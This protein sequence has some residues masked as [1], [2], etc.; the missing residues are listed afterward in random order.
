[1]IGKVL[2]FKPLADRV[3]DDVEYV[4][5]NGV[6]VKHEVA[7]PSSSDMASWAKANPVPTLLGLALTGLVVAKLVK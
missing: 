1:M 6:K 2:R 7:A 3:F 4:L 5:K